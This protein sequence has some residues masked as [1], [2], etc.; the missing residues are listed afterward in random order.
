MGKN[1]KKTM[2]FFENVIMG[3]NDFQ[4][5]FL[6]EFY[7]E[8]SVATFLGKT[9]FSLGFFLLVWRKIGRIKKQRLTGDGGGLSICFLV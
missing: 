5:D 4:N 3:K 6:R 2:F 1:M 8:F 7:Y 9:F